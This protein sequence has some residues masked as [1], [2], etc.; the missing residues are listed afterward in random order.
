MKPVYISIFYLFPTWKL[1]SLELA[2][3]QLY[4]PHSRTL[5]HFRKEC[6]L[7]L[8][9][10]LRSRFMNLIAAAITAWFN[11]RRICIYFFTTLSFLT[12]KYP[13]NNCFHNLIEYDWHMF[14]KPPLTNKTSFATSKRQN[15]SSLM[16]LLQDKF[17]FFLR[18]TKY[19]NVFAGIK[20]T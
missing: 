14:I 7:M 3:M 10:I 6:L 12:A 19:Y 1:S 13:A 15:Q 11:Y 18:Q 17:V 9:K 2:K 4:F 5:F 20:K 8:I 16:Y